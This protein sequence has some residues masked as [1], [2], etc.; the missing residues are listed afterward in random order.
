MPFK[1]TQQSLILETFF[2]ISNDSE[3]KLQIWLLGC[4][5]AG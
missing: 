1:F 5:I 3:S 2:Q 4:L